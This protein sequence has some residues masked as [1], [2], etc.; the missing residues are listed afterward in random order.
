M[1]VTWEAPIKTV[2]EANRSEHWTVRSK[3]H[4]IQQHFI[5]LLFNG[6]KGPIPLPC[7]VKMTRV[8]GRRLDDDNL[9]VAL[10]YVRDEISACLIPEKRAYYVD[11]KGKTRELKGRADDDNRI[12]WEYG[13]KKG[14]ILGLKIE[15]ETLDIGQLQ[16]FQDAS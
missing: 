16:E 5:S 15:I 7:C 11:R 10:K 4:K 6:L 13:Q 8:G 9:C 12:K 3:R 1:K 2:S 14:K